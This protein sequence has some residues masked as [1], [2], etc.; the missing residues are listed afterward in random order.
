M[1]SYTPIPTL[2]GFTDLNKNISVWCP[3]CKTFHH[4]G[5][6]PGPRTPHCWP[7]EGRYY[8]TSDYIIKEYT[9]TDLKPFKDSILDL[10]LTDKEKK[11]INSTKKWY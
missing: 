9:K 7:K 3:E 1:K 8:K 10:I 4:H 2:K 5:K 11:A 6:G